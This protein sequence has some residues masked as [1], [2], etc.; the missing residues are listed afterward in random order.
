[1]FFIKNI[2]QYLIAKLYLNKFKDYF[3]KYNILKKP[4]F[5]DQEKLFKKNEYVHSF[6]RLNLFVNKNKINQKKLI[7][8]LKKLKINCGV[9]P[10]PEIYREKIFKK[11]K[12]YPKKRLINAKLLGETS[13]MI[14]INPYRSLKKINSEIISI[15]K[16]LNKY[17]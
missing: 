4:Y 12:Y 13:I 1:M 16:I 3:L 10:C 11:L 17:L 14:P 6:Y 8:K 9:G 15:K 5:I 7:Q 2:E